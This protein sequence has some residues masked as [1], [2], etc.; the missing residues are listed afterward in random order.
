MIMIK[1]KCKLDGA[2]RVSVTTRYFAGLII[3]EEWI[4]FA[5]FFTEVNLSSTSHDKRKYQLKL[6][7]TDASFILQPILTFKEIDYT[8]E[9]R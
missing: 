3:I 8:G 1:G 6:E 2:G 5:H 9:C 4:Q 7:K